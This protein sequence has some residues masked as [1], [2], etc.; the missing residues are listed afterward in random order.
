MEYPFNLLNPVYLIDLV[1]GWTSPVDLLFS[2]KYFWGCF[3]VYFY[4]PLCETILKL[5]ESIF[6]YSIWHSF[7][8]MRCLLYK[9]IELQTALLLLLDSL[10]THI[11]GFIYS[12]DIEVIQ[13]DL[14]SERRTA[15]MHRIVG[16]PITCHQSNS[17]RGKT[18]QYCQQST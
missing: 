8:Q 18:Q 5:F 3:N 12:I 13:S 16:K 2:Q 9:S 17:R 1:W 15:Q 11:L 14:Q 4:V 6:R 10:K 7:Y